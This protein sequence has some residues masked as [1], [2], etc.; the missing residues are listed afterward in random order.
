VA[1]NRCA[2]VASA[3]RRTGWAALLV[4]ASLANFTAARAADPQSI[5]D[6]TAPPAR[7]VVTLSPHLT[8]LV[9]AAGGGD[10]LVGVMRYSDYPA[11][12]LAL[13]VIGDAFAINLEAIAGLKPDLVLAWRSGTNQRQRDRLQALRVRVVD[14]EI[15]R[16]EDIAASLRQIGSL[17]GT[18]AIADA[19]AIQVEQRWRR[20][21]AA[22][23]HDKP[24]RVFYQLWAEPL[25]TVSRSHLVDQAIGACGGVNVFADQPGMTPTVGWEAVAR[26][27]PQ[28]VIATSAQDEP[29]QLAGWQKLSRVDAVRHHHLVTLDGH[30]LA[31][32]TPRFLDAAEALCTAIAVAR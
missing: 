6:S 30:T 8:E 23:A 2:D 16:V 7:R 28:I 22:H 5:A 20:L 32:M 26:A 15:E 14:N 1:E 24:V 21:L 11:A 4:A 29:A 12:A 31:R 10:R 13:P 3:A 19:A 27:N 17:L 9:F 25:M 18:Q